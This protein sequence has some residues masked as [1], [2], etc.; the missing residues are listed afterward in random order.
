MIFGFGVDIVGFDVCLLGQIET[1]WQLSENVDYVIASEELEPGDGWEYTAF[2]IVCDNPNTTPT[3]LIDEIVNLYFSYSYG[4]TQAGQ[5]LA[6]LRGALTTDLNNFCAELIANCYDHKSDMT[7]ARNSAWYS[8]YNPDCRDI[9]EFADAISNDSDL[10]ASLKT[11]ASDFCDEWE[12]FIVAGGLHHSSDDA[13][14]ATVYFP[15][16]ADSDSNWNTYINKITFTD[17]S[18]DEFLIEYDDPSP[19]SIKSASLGEIKATFK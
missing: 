9:Y 16:N 3:E 11:A 8:Y 5:D 10:P 1:G 19:S 6:V 2:D 4:D 15:T 7:S 12:N 17:T 13:S 18:W 14:G